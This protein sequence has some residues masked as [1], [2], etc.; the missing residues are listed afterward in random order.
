MLKRKRR[1]PA[2]DWLAKYGPLLVSLFM[3]IGE[4]FRK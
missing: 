3:A 4:W 2:P 1:K